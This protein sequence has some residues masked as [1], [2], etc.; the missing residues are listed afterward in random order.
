[1][2]VT[3]KQL[4][5]IIMEELGRTL[6]ES[7]H[8][9]VP[10]RRGAPAEPAASFKAGTATAE[11]LEELPPSSKQVSTHSIEGGT[12]HYVG[13]GFQELTRRIFQRS[14]VPFTGAESNDDNKWW[15]YGFEE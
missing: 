14:G 6:S 15:F 9:P 2:R 13:P 5:R 1:M 4:R 12:L 11:M 10:R 7:R 8:R 3:R